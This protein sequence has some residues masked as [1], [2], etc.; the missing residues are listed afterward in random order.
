MVLHATDSCTPNV[1]PRINSNNGTASSSNWNAD[2]PASRTPWSPHRLRSS[3]RRRTERRCTLAMGAAVLIVCARLPCPLMRLGAAQIYSATH[4]CC[5]TRGRRVAEVFLHQLEAA[6]GQR[7]VP[8]VTR[9]SQFSTPAQTE[10]R[11]RYVDLG[12]CGTHRAGRRAGSAC[13]S[14]HRSVGT[15][16]SGSRHPPQSPAGRGAIRAAAT[17]CRTTALE[18]GAEHDGR[19]VVAG[20]DGGSERVG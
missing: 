7:Q 9:N 4:G 3:G 14:S 13:S 6:R 18:P 19:L 10:H 1:F 20:T 16:L 17:P 8:C 12:L 5:G 15:R 11:G 2:S